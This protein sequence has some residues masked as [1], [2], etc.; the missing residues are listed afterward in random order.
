MIGF[1][2]GW[3]IVVSL[4]SANCISYEKTEVPLKE[5]LPF[6]PRKDDM[7]FL[8]DEIINELDEINCCY[9]CEHYGKCKDE[10]YIRNAEDAIFVHDVI[11]STR[12]NIIT[13]VLGDYKL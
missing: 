6:I 11:I 13:L 1:D 7:I 10:S 5:G 2:D 3:K 4:A 8:D 12:Q 9:E